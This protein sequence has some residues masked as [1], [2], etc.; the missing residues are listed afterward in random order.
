L[1]ALHLT[2]SLAY[3]IHLWIQKLKRQQQSSNQ[4][5]SQMQ[6]QDRGI[7]NQAHDFTMTG[8]TFNNGRIPFA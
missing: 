8:A 1:D 6:C 5:L 3:E 2:V 7:L 4:Y